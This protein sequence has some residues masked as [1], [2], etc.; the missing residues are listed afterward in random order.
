MSAF[1]DRH[2]GPDAVE[3]AIMLETLG[4]DSLDALID[5]TV[6]EAIRDRTPVSLPAAVDEVEVIT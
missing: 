6:P 4:F 2:I 1:A 3:Q 5:A